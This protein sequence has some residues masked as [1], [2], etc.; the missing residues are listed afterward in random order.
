MLTTAVIAISGCGGGSGSPTASGGG[1]GAGTTNPPPDSPRA[2]SSS[3]EVP[4]LNGPIAD[5]AGPKGR[6]FG[7]TVAELAPLE[8]YGYVE[9]EYFFS[10]VAQER[11]EDGA[12][13]GGPEAEF[14]S[15]ILVRRPI[16]PAAFNGTIFLE[17]YN[18]TG[19]SDTDVLWNAAH[20]MLMREGFVHVGVSAQQTGVSGNSPLALK[21]W[22]PVRYGPL[23]HPGDAYSWDIYAQAG[24]VL[25]DK[26]LQ[27]G[28]MGELSP[29]RIIA[30][31]ESQSSFRL[32]A[33]SDVIQREHQLFDG[34]FLHTGPVQGKG[35]DDVGVPVMHF[36][37]ETEIDG[38]LA[39]E[40][41]GAVVD[42]TTPVV[43]SV[44][45]PLPPPYGPD[46][47]MIRVWEV[48]G[49]SHF[50]KQLWAY[51]TAF[52]AR[53]ASAPADIPVYV[54]QP[55]F[56]G[57][58]MNQ[59]GQ[60]RATAAAL[61]HLNRWVTTGVVPESMPRIELND[62]YRIVRDDDGLAR[63]GIRLPSLEAPIG[64][65]RGDECT[66]WG[67]FQEFSIADIQARYPTHSDYVAA[68]TAS[69]MRNVNQ[70]SLLPE[71]ALLYI[72]EAQALQTYWLPQ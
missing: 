36:I 49:S 21:N 41:G 34:F 63:G 54:E 59:L 66:F 31:G 24:R 67:S 5:D 7:A 8:P 39:T 19:Q 61:H 14:V 15:R 58:P 25:F 28:P 62:N 27:P 68:V 72:E 42:Y 29:Q 60:G 50:D 9:E 55:A 37:S 17:W 51:A 44:V 71:E 48:A 23:L 52:A 12:L 69:A 30:G 3:V 13:T 1:S 2:E 43:D 65:N 57:L 47:G 32:V 18:V 40:Q 6:Y 56:C 46:R 33:Y 20:D 70:G 10:G 22:D 11:D 64:I 38:I 45:E 16:D 35:V 4:E 26:A 53:E